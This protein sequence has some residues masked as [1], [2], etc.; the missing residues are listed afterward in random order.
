MGALHHRHVAKCQ[1]IRQYVELPRVEPKSAILVDI[2]NSPFFIEESDDILAID[3][4]LCDLTF[5]NEVSTNDV[6]LEE[7]NIRYIFVIS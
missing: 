4:I 6:F 7:N 5:E 2:D 1:K 3:D